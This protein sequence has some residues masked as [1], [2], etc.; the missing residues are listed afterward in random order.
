MGGMYNVFSTEAN[1]LV[2]FHENQ[3]YYR[4]EEFD[5]WHL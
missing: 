5:T 1:L 3:G 2:K 4:K